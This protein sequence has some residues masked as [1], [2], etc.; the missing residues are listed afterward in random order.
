MSWTIPERSVEPDPQWT[1]TLVGD[2]GSRMGRRKGWTVKP[3]KRDLKGT[4]AG[5]GHLSRCSELADSSDGN[6]GR[7]LARTPPISRSMPASV[8]RTTEVILPLSALK[9]IVTVSLSF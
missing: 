9:E 6:R 8:S 2:I 1:V 7:T 5:Q 4:I 3:L